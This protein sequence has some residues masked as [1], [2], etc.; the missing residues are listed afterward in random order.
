M[1]QTDRCCG[2][3]AFWWLCRW[4]KD[5]QKIDAETKLPCLLLPPVLK[6]IEIGS[7][8]QPNKIKNDEYQ[9][10]TRRNDYCGQHKTIEEIDNFDWCESQITKSNLRCEALS[11]FLKKW[12]KK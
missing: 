10:T 9:P 7:P 4:G 8:Y 1:K 3:C 2:N 11:R 6:A 12:V 5:I